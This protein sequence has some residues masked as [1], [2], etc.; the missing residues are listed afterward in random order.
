MI[1]QCLRATHHQ[2]LAQPEPPKTRLCEEERRSNLLSLP[3]DA[4]QVKLKLSANIKPHVLSSR[5]DRKEQQLAVVLTTARGSD[6]RPSSPGLRQEIEN[7]VIMPKR[8]RPLGRI[9]KKLM[10]NKKGPAT[11]KPAT[12]LL[13][14][15]QLTAEQ[16]KQI[17]DAFPDLDVVDAIKKPTDVAAHI[18]GIEIAYGNVPQDAFICSDQLKWIH[19]VS[20]GVEGILYKEVIE[21]DV[22]VTNGGDNFSQACAEN[23]LMTILAF[24]RQLPLV[25]D[26][27]RN[28]KWH[29]VTS[30]PDLLRGR[31]V[32]HLGTGNVA[33]H[34]ARLFE[35]FQCRNIGYNRT[36]RAE[37][38]FETV[39]TKDDLH[40]MLAESDIIVN[41]LPLTNETFHMIGETEFRS[42]KHTSI[43]TNVGRGKTVGENAL[44]QALQSGQIAGA[45]LDVF[46]EEPLPP[47][48]P[49][50]PMENVII[51]PHY[52]G[53]GGQDE[54][55]RSFSLFFENLVRYQEGRPLLHQA[56]F[57][58]GY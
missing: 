17:K 13:S 53:R 34:I 47:E 31:T 7:R 48:S 46:E 16:M 28:A 41:S 9:L 42:M 51:T 45:C 25:L 38:P 56:N 37:A 1:F 39:Y 19:V 36:G 11:V 43:F 44:I 52:G 32:G 54:M 8:K 55:E 2:N 10:S 57:Q 20:Q 27:Q 5:R 40:Q 58:T 6:R 24:Y 26:C 12:K 15:A 29:R 22:I 35:A 49:L 14:R 18:R 21:S 50:W 30:P 3:T 33:K 23:V 4:Q